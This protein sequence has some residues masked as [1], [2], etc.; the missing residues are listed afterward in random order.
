MGIYG[1][2]TTQSQ[3]I[4]TF[5]ITNTL[6]CSQKANLAVTF[7]L[8]KLVCKC[9]AMCFSPLSASEKRNRESSRNM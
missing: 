4:E 2:L 9:L 5:I 7:E 3:D 6:K 8:L 1:L